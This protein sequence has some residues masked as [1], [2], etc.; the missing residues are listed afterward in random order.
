M[1][2]HRN[3]AANKDQPML[4]IDIRDRS[5]TTASTSLGRSSTARE[6]SAMAKPVRPAVVQ[7][8]DGED[9]HWI[10]F[11]GPHDRRPT[12]QSNA[13]SFDP[14]KRHAAAP[15]TI[16]AESPC[17]A[18]APNMASQ[19]KLDCI[20]EPLVVAPSMATEPLE[21]D[22]THL[23]GK[24]LASD[25]SVIQRFD[26]PQALAIDVPSRR[27][28][29]PASLP[30]AVPTI[31]LAPT[32]RSFERWEPA[33]EVDGWQFPAAV[34]RLAESLGESFQGLSEHL[35]TA[36]HDGLQVL[37][38]TS[39]HRGQGRTT[40]SLLI[41]KAAAAAGLRVALVDG[42]LQQPGLAR[43]LA[44]EVARGW[45][46]AL[47]ERTPIDDV[48]VHALRD[49]I[50]VV[51]LIRAGGRSTPTPATIEVLAMLDRLAIHHDLVIVDAG[52]ILDVGATLIG[53]GPICR[54]DAAMIIRDSRQATA[55]RD[56]QASAERLRHLGVEQVG[57]IDVIQ[58][59]RA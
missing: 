51:P 50:T 24:G 53:A 25:Q 54:I 49:R 2:T 45:S 3:A 4:P 18:A 27:D 38:I 22:V 26:Q 23:F 12:S 14:G 29:R 48:A 35:A 33:W 17:A 19:W 6:P 37:A 32:A 13:V 34:N 43:S 46:D 55:S 7:W 30:A 59:P 57:L 20:S 10:R 28:E 40:Q 21:L 47:C 31:P 36:C 41:A 15:Q 11:E 1:T 42:D 39:P 16:R 5:P 58:S 56:C 9:E 44:L 8:L 52:P